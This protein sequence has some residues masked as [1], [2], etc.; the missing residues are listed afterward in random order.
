MEQTELKGNYYYTSYSHDVSDW[1]GKKPGADPHPEEREFLTRN[2]ERSTRGWKPE[3]MPVKTRELP[4]SV[5]T[6]AFGE[7]QMKNFQRPKKNYDSPDLTK[8]NIFTPTTE[9]RD[10]YQG[11]Y[12]EP[13]LN[14]LPY[15]K[16]QPTGNVQTRDLPAEMVQEP[17]W[18]TTY[19]DGYC[20]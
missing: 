8:V 9:Y 19:R 12:G 6:M 18:S 2:L 1:G 7:T 10:N 15:D 11:L 13:F 20:K 5:Q 3:V 4:Q 16:N 17:K 14:Q